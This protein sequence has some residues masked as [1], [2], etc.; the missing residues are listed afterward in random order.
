MPNCLSAV[1]FDLCFTAVPGEDVS[2][3]SCRRLISPA[4]TQA[5]LVDSTLWGFARKVVRGPSDKSLERI[6]C[7]LSRALAQ[8]SCFSLFA[9]FDSQMDDVFLAERHTMSFL[10]SDFVTLN[11]RL[12]WTVHNCLDAFLTQKSVR[13]IVEKYIRT[14]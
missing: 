8:V 9:Y 11:Y 1:A 7:W 12:Q 14:P 13:I 10:T 5:Q 6:P 3:G 4:L 2:V